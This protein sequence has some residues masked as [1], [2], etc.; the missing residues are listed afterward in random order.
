MSELEVRNAE[1]R[2][3]SLMCDSLSAQIATNAKKHALDMK[4]MIG[5][6]EERIEDMKHVKNIHIWQ[7]ECFTKSIPSIVDE[8]HIR[9]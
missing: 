4:E 2:D 6:F 9:L 7:W 5:A 1:N 8:S 3:L